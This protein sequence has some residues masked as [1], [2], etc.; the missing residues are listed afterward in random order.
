MGD[1]PKPRAR[2]P[3]FSHK[4]AGHKRRLIEGDV[5][6]IVR[7]RSDN[8]YYSHPCI[9]MHT[10]NTF[11]VCIGFRLLKSCTKRASFPLAVVD[12]ERTLWSGMVATDVGT[13][14]GPATTLSKRNCDRIGHYCDESCNTLKVDVVVATTKS[15]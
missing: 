3:Q 13:R 9:A 2:S 15:A 5:L 14:S 4:G 12:R 10:T 7:G 6:G 1:T 8:A 11:R